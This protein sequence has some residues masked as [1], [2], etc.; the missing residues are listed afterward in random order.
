MIT[1]FLNR[2]GMYFAI[3]ICL[4]LIIWSY[5]EKDFYVDSIDSLPDSPTWGQF[6]YFVGD[7]IG[8]IFMK[9]TIYIF[10]WVIIG[11]NI[12][13]QYKLIDRWFGR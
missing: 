12:I 2:F 10:P 11:A 13:W 8:Y 6:W 9:W 5:V 7:V 3:A 4:T 1:K